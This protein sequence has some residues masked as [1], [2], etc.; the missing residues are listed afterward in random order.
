[1]IVRLS[2]LKLQVI[3][4]ALSHSSCDYIRVTVRNLTQSSIF[5]YSSNQVFILKKIIHI[6][7]LLPPFYSSLLL[8]EWYIK[9]EAFLET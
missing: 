2:S 8:S 3:P 5:Q 7:A 4:L 9:P 1:M 6:P